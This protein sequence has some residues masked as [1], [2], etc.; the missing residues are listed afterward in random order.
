MILYF[1]GTGNSKYVAEAIANFM[2]DEVISLNTIIKENKKAQF[3]SSKPYLIVAPIYAWRF[4]HIIE[5]LL[6]NADFSGSNDFYFIGTMGS[7]S[8]NCDKYLKKICD[9]KSMN[10]MGFCGVRMP[11]NYVISD[12]MA[13]KEQIK[14]ILNSADKEIADIAKHIGNNEKISKNDKT[15]FSFIMSGL[16]NSMFSKYMVSSQDYVVSEKCVTCGKCEQLCPVNNIVITNGKPQFGDKCINC[17]ACIHHCPQAAID[18][19]GKTETHGRY[20]CPDYKSE[21]LKI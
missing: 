1:T 8:G 10:Y 15:A 14:A 6:K 4:P 5:D 17:Y 3:N 9:E 2:G 12:I 13:E 11:S 16:V 21:H 19:K 18:I 20:V 7:Q